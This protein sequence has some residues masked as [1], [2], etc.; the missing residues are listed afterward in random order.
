MIP[1]HV[2]GGYLGAG[3]T[4]ALQ[5]LLAQLP[6]DAPIGL[7]VND[8]GAAEIDASTFQGGSQLRIRAIPNACLCCTAPAGFVAAVSALLAE[9]VTRI[10]VEPT[11][12]AR[13]ADVLDTARR[14][15]W[16]DRVT[17][18]P[19][20]VLV[21]P[22]GLDDPARRAQA[23]VAEVLVFNRVDRAS[24]EALAD[25][26]AWADGLW[27][28]PLA[29]HWTQYGQLPLAALDRPAPDRAPP[30]R[31]AFPAPDHGMDVQSWVW[32][33]AV[34]FSAAAVR[35]A[36]ADPALVRAKGVLRTDEGM[37]RAER[38]GDAVELV[39]SDA[40]GDSRLDA[41]A[42]RGSDALGRLDAALSLARDAVATAVLGAVEVVRADGRVE[43]WDR[44]RLAALPGLADVGE[45]VPGR[46]GAAA[47][48]AALL[49]D[50]P[51]DGTVVVVAADGFV[52]EPS[53]VAVA[54]TGWLAHSVG[55]APLPD[56]A[57]GPFRWLLPPGT[58]SPCA[59]VKAVIRVVI[60][61]P[62][63]V[64]R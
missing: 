41:L 46:T 55:S 54:R 43:Q 47:A 56:T 36:L 62:G 59:N 27:P 8:F 63:A 4:T 15:P 42:P 53:P 51:E 60:R 32:G 57:G 24:P 29:V 18:G 6:G 64:T 37:V 17:V 40:C 9:G 11:G 13:P 26:R 39:P 3:K 50:A 48:L 22:V 12:L 7:I 31:F 19:L 2:I 44:A 28:A 49:A 10:F 30:P 25:A 14:A 33:P 35:A 38:A 21:D 34:R 1:L 45:R 61:P 58:I 16:R 52:A 23:A 20:V 5:H